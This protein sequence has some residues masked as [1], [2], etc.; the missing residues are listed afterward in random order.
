MKYSPQ[1]LSL[2]L[3]LSWCKDENKTHINDVMDIDLHWNIELKSMFASTCSAESVTMT[4][5]INCKEGSRPQWPAFKP[6][7]LVR[8]Y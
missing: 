8:F 7:D 3:G 2:S 6:L 4:M 1:T 5:N